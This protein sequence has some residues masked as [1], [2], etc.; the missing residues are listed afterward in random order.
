LAQVSVPLPFT[1]VPL[2]GQTLGVLLVGAALG[3]RRGAA[4]LAL[5]TLEGVAG[6][7][8]FAGGAAGP[9]RLLGPTGGYLVG[10]IAA[11]YVVGALAE[12]GLDRRWRTALLPFLLGS[13]TIYLFGVTWLAVYLGWLP[14]LQ[15][16]LWP[17]L[18]GDALKLLLAAGA[19][20]AAWA[21]VR[22]LE[23]P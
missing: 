19:L 23:R 5:Y 4:S 8:V 3:R 22:R 15:N 10:F 16:G 17:F 6:L 2:T 21:L 11:A 12:R 14:A 7:P 1:P 13:L 20:P 18:L 9:A